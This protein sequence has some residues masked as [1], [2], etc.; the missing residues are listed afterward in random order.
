LPDR[1]RRIAHAHLQQ[2]LPAANTV[3]NASPQALTL[4][5]SEGIETQF[6]GV[7]LTGPQQKPS[8]SVNPSAA[9]AIR[10]S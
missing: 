7:T 3:V 5:F 2:Q 10:L 1:S 9:T 6:S 4:N 8:P